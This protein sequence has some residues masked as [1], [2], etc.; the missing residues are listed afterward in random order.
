MSAI[1]KMD[2]HD[3]VAAIKPLFKQK[4]QFYHQFQATYFQITMASRWTVQ[5]KSHSHLNTTKWPGNGGGTGV[6]VS[7][8]IAATVVIYCAANI[9]EQLIMDCILYT[10][11]KSSQNCQDFARYGKIQV[12]VR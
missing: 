5:C 2:L 1:L 8:I 3:T 7:I 12:N 11:K 10:S 6:F 9:L 4:L